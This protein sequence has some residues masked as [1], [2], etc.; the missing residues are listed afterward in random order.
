[1]LRFIKAFETVYSIK[2]HERVAATLNS[3]KKGA[4]KEV[5]IKKARETTV[6]ALSNAKQYVS[7]DDMDYVIKLLW[8]RITN[9][10]KVCSSPDNDVSLMPFATID[11]PVFK[12]SQLAVLAMDVMV[13]FQ[14]TVGCFGARGQ[15]TE[16]QTLAHM[17]R[18]LDSSCRQLD[19]RSLLS[20]S[21]NALC[22]QWGVLDTHEKVQDRDFAPIHICLPHR[23][24]VHVVL[25]WW[26][27]FTTG[28]RWDVAVSRFPQMPLFVHFIELNSI[29]REKGSSM[30]DVRL[31]SAYFDRY[32][33]TRANFLGQLSSM[34]KSANPPQSY[35]STKH[36]T[37]MTHIQNVNAKTLRRSQITAQVIAWNS[38]KGCFSHLHRQEFLE[39]LAKLANTSSKEILETYSLV[40]VNTDAT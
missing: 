25:K 22:H 36:L 28:L 38:K 1:M 26:V 19:L 27:A 35:V 2:V 9:W 23:K 33:P 7:P 6:Q 8:E 10:M 39:N 15:F 11:N 30:I 24:F 5:T 4:K 14:F 29:A 13:F 40:P 18:F 3:L 21:R 16:V 34:F 12:P 20:T 37:H 32:R 17:G 31:S